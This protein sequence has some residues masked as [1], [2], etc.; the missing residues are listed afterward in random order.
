MYVFVHTWTHMSTGTYG[1]QNRVLPHPQK[2]EL[3]VAVCCLTW[4]LGTELWVH[5]KSSACS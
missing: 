4:M 5:C 2:L 1:G 3:Q